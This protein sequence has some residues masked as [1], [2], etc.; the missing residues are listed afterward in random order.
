MIFESIVVKSPNF[1]GRLHITLIMQYTFITWTQNGCL[2]NTLEIVI[3]DSP[4]ASFAARMLVCW[5]FQ[6][7]AIMSIS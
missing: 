2:F 3:L 1:G 5:L 6:K 7:N 4:K